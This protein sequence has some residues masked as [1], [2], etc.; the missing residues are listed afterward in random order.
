MAKKSFLSKITID[1]YVSVAFVAISVLFLLIDFFITK[2]KIA[3]FLSS[4]IMHLL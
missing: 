3:S 4:P 2:G 1:S